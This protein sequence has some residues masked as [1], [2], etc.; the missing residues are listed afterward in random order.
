MIENKGPLSGITVIDLTTEVL[1]PVGTQLLGDFGAEVIKIESLAG[2]P[3][4]KNGFI[5]AEG[6]TSIYLSINRNKKSI[7]IDLKTDDGKKVLQAL[8]SKADVIIHNIR[9]KSTERIGIDYESIKKINP[10]IIYCVATGFDQDGP[11]K[12]Q[13]AFDDIIQAGCGAVHL[14]SIGKETP[15]FLPTVIGDKSVGLLLSNAV[16][17][18]LFYRERT[19]VSQF[20]EIPLYESTVAFTMLEHMGGMTT[21]PQSGESGYLRILDKGRKLYPTKNGYFAMLPYTSEQWSKL[22]EIDDKVQLGSELGIADRLTRNLN[23]SVIYSE[24]SKI[25]AKQTLDQMQEICFKFDIPFSRINSPEQLLI[26][27]QLKEVKLFVED[28]HPTAGHIRYIRPT[29][30][31]SE[32]PVSVRSLAS[33]LGGDTKQVLIDLGYTEVEINSLS[34]RGIIKT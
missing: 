5:L 2:D 22:F 7:S 6:I 4:R 25:T 26:D 1:G 13:P 27:N 31:F 11:N 23:F 10:K 15:E 30:K 8:I 21:V 32:T 3:Q 33:Q 19:G 12:D 16:I 34:I 28:V 17:A 29:A 24:M 18:A 14:N 9:M 20:I